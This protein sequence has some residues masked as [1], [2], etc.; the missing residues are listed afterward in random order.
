MTISS[1]LPTQEFSLDAMEQLPGF[2]SI[3]SET[4]RPTFIRDC[5]EW[6]FDVIEFNGR[7]AQGEASYFTELAK[8]FEFPDYFGG[9]WDAVVDC[10]TDLEWEEGDC[11]MVLYSAA[12]RLAKAEPL[13]WK[14]M[15]EIWQRVVDH[16]SDLGVSLYL[17]FQ[18]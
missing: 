5:I 18:D 1:H 15:M 2:Y 3:D 10:L 14:T 16:W 4:D 13:S 9:N 7:K 8:I 12:D 17:V 11:I 6:G